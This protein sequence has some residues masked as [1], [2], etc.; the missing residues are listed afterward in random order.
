M[1]VVVDCRGMR[2]AAHTTA[3]LRAHAS[4]APPDPRSPAPCRHHPVRM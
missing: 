1:G 3:W 4:W 2:G